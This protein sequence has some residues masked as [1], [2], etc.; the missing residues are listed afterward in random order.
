MFVSVIYWCKTNHLKTWWPKCHSG[1]SGSE[2]QDGP[3]WLHSPVWQALLAV[4]WASLSSTW[5]VVHKEV[6]LTPS[7]DHFWAPRG[8]E[9]KPQS[10]PRPW[11]Q[12]A[13][14]A[15]LPHCIGQSEMG[16]PRWKSWRN[17]LPFWMQWV[18]KSC[19]T[20]RD[21]FERLRKQ[22][23]AGWEVTYLNAV[24]FSTSS[25][26]AA[27]WDALI[28]GSFLSPVPLRH[29]PAGN[30]SYNAAI[31]RIEAF[32]SSHGSTRAIKRSHPFRRP[33]ELRFKG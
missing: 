26:K 33:G 4:S 3:L 21:P 7:Y 10:L 22:S 14:N 19:C 30:P 15:L 16:Q 24:F 28:P 18:A 11:L 23:T 17:K 9:K 31:G 20:G 27:K 29:S 25:V 8:K 6:H 2:G 13:H 12:S 32:F 1:F 5:P